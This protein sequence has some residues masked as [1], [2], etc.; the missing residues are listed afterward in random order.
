MGIFLSLPLLG[1]PTLT[2]TKGLVSVISA[3]S[4][5]FGKFNYSIGISGFSVISSDSIGP[6][7][8]EDG[9]PYSGEKGQC[10]GADFSLGF[11]FSF[12]DYLSL[13]LNSGFL[14]DVMETEIK[15]PGAGGVSYGFE[16]TRLGLKFTPTQAIRAVKPGFTKLLDLGIYPIVSFPTGTERKPLS[17]TCGTDTIPFLLYPYRLGEGGI[18]RFFTAGGTAYGGKGLFT[19]N[20]PTQP[21]LKIHLNAGYI[22]YPKNCSKYIYGTGIELSYFKFASFVEVYGEK[23]V[24]TKYNDGGLY[25]SPGLRFE[26]AKNNWLTIAID[27][28]LSGS[29]TGFTDEN[30]NIQRGFGATPPWTVNLTLSQG[31]DFIKP[32]I[33]KGMIAGRVVDKISEKPL[34]AIVS[35]PEFDTT[36]TTDEQGTYEIGLP[37]GK[38]LVYASPLQKE[39]YETSSELTILVEEAKKTVANFRLERKK[40]YV[41][42][43]TGK[44]IDKVTQKPCLASISFPETEFPEAKSDISGIYKTELPPGTYVVR[45]EKASYIPWTQ[46]VVLKPDETTVLN[47]ELSPAERMSTLIGKVTDYSTHQGIKAE[48]EFPGTELPGIQTDPETGTYRVEI[49]SGTYNIK[50]KAEG[51][52]PEGA[53]IVCEPDA[54]LIKD[55]E[56]FKKEE[57]IVLH[58]ITF[59]FNKADIRQSSYPILDEAVELLKKHPDVNVEIAGHTDNVGSDAYNLKLSQQRATAV[60]EYLIMH[61]IQAQRLR[62]QGYGESQPIADNETKDG[63]AQNRRIEFRILQK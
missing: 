14:A 4:E 7:Y 31:F 56:L 8:D 45:V 34:K 26:T 13:N 49:P 22:H 17:K 39:A 25:L 3:T 27:F 16:D 63:Q 38:V 35:F 46:P 30:L 5:P 62:A 37:P 40:V 23:R 6:V 32:P 36:I 53:A 10:V 47:V 19:F 29:D 41:S 24:E 28:R 12:T 55:F 15:C 42:L 44:I 59:A 43:L 54:S 61:G 60:K 51:Y 33:K 50:I 11:G 20:I 58:G 2:G 52:I 21:E 9:K 1:A 57:K 48:I 18:H